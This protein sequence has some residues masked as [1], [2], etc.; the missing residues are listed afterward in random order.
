MSIKFQRTG[1]NWTVQNIQEDNCSL[2]VDNIEGR[3]CTPPTSF[4]NSRPKLGRRGGSL[5]VLQ[6]YF[7][8]LESW[9]ED[10]RSTIFEYKPHLTIPI[11]IM[12][13]LVLE[14]CRSQNWTFLSSDVVKLPLKNQIASQ[15]AFVSLVMEA[16]L[17][18]SAIDLTVLQGPYLWSGFWKNESSKISRHMCRVKKYLN[19]RISFE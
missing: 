7:P 6:V 19:F 9:P 1:R 4:L 2:Y 11:L 10:I 3:D 17:V 14:K 16:T 8:V 18:P 15:A 12:R 13:A 5:Y